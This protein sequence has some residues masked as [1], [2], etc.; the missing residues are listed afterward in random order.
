MW[1]EV[2]TQVEQDKDNSDNTCFDPN[3]AF[4]D[5]DNLPKDHVKGYHSTKDSPKVFSLTAAPL[6]KDDEFN[7]HVHSLNER[8]RKMF[9][10]IMVWSTVLKHVMSPLTFYIFLSGGAGVGKSHLIHAITKVCHVSYVY[11]D[12]IQINLQHS[13]Y[14]PNQQQ[15][16]V[17]NQQEVIKLNNTVTINAV[18]SKRDKYTN[19][20]NVSVPENIGLYNTGN[21]PKK[22]TLAYGA[23]VMLTKNVDISDHLVNGI[24]GKVFHVQLPQSH[25]KGTI[26][27][28]FG[29]Q[30][31]G[32]TAKMGSPSHLK[33]CVPITAVTASFLLTKPA[34]IT[35][36]RTMFPLVL[37]YAITSHKSQGGTYEHVIANLEK[38]SQVTSV[39]PGQVYTILSRVT[40]RQG[41]KLINFSKDKIKVNNEALHEMDSMRS[42]RQFHCEHRFPNVTRTIAYLNI[43]RPLPYRDSHKRTELERKSGTIPVELS[44]GDLQ[45]IEGISTSGHKDEKGNEKSPAPI[46]RTQNRETPN[47]PYTD[48]PGSDARRTV[49]N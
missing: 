18:D 4:I 43:Y 29:D 27:V 34:F 37:A 1:Q 47:T 48:I 41:L 8:Q 22:I 21:L 31:V 44:Q 33:K 13:P 26:Y 40:S 6:M 17:H 5:T 39:M 3:H 42:T 11:L 24:I 14:L 19:T 46:P 2:A 35:V 30:I 9:D 23:K 15:V 16:D 12:R 32:K 45:V 49:T 28:D 7:K 10:S 20:V 38:P 36:E 25:L